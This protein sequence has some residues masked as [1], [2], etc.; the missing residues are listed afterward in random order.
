[1]VIKPTTFNGELLR[2]DLPFDQALEQLT[3]RVAAVSWW[4]TKYG[5]MEL[6]HSTVKT[7]EN[8]V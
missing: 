3:A 1:L 7:E 2:L 5:G 6:E 8:Q 4:T